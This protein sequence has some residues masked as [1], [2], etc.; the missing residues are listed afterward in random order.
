MDEIFK[1]DGPGNLNLAEALKKTRVEVAEKKPVKKPKTKK[2]S[3][4]QSDSSSCDE[5]EFVW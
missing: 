2:W 1:F 3:S 5:G 4:L